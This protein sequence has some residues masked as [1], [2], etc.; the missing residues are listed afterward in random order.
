ML[1]AIDDVMALHEVDV[2]PIPEEHIDG[3]GHLSVRFIVEIAAHGAHELLVGCGLTNERRE[4]THQGV[5]TAEHHIAYIA[6]M[7]ADSDL[8][9]Y[10]RVLDRSPR[11]VILLAFVV[12]RTRQRVAAVL[13]A[14]VVSVAL[15]TR[16]STPFAREIASEID[17]LLSDHDALGWSPPFP[18]WGRLPGGRR[19][20][21]R[22]RWRRVLQM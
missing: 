15:D 16:R 17:R 2:A 9:V 4:R 14:V 8:A 12:D 5:F 20:G 7:R 10:V 11:A 18:R 22:R 19:R 3:N 6:E 21:W 13:R 1:P